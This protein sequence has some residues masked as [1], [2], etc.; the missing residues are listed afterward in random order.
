[1]SNQGILYI[2]ATPIGNLEDMSRRAIKI[3]SNV[4]V[5]AAEDTRTTRHLLNH[6]DIANLLTSYHEHNEAQKSVELLAKLQNGEDVALVSEAGT[7]T[8]S[9]PGYRLV[10]QA[11]ENGVKLVP[12][13]GPS[14]VATALSISGLPTDR[15]MFV[16]FLPDKTGK[17]KKKLDELKGEL[18]TLV[19]YISKWKLERVLTDML[20]MFGDR[21]VCFCR[22]LTKMHE[23]IRHTTL[24]SLLED[25]S[26][27]KVKGEITLVVE[28][29]EK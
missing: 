29:C 14:A 27:K 23:D 26:G 16:G 5:I 21:R 7:P 25:C 9:D 11:V 8:I 28:G 20:E 24:D 3:L 22:E 12:V 15:F 19:F 18:A 10:Q 6:F 13:P 4:S 1:M 17:R 2:V